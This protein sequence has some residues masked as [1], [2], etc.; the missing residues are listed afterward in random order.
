DKV[1]DGESLGDFTFFA[2]AL[3][4]S[5]SNIGADGLSVRAAELEAAGRAGDLASIR[6]NLVAF[7]RDLHLL[8]VRVRELLA[9]SRPGRREGGVGPDFFR[10][11]AALRTALDTFDVTAA[12]NALERLKALPLSTQKHEAVVEIADYVL[13]ADYQKAMESV[14][15]LEE[16]MAPAD[17]LAPPRP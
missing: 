5:L 16:G 15:T 17:A 2:H 14:I 4:S 10:L 13:T 1:Q 7:R 9:Y 11:L 12:D 8:G 6:D 3:K